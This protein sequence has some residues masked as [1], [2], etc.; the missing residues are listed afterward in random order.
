MTRDLEFGGRQEAFRRRL[1]DSGVTTRTVAS[2]AD[3]ETAVLASAVT[4]RR[5][6]SPGEQRLRTVGQQLFDSLFSGP[7]GEA[8]RTSV[9]SAT[10]VAN[11]CRWCSGWTFPGWP[12]F[13]VESMYD[14]QNGE[15]AS[16]LPTR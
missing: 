2:P 15:Q 12:P 10:R 5:I 11:G 14:T 16:A 6:L 13:R 3:L 9:D 1:A 4:G 7:V 8:Y